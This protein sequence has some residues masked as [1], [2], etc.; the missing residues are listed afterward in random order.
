[1]SAPTT[2]DGR[3][4]DPATGETRPPSSSRRTIPN[5]QQEQHHPD[6]RLAPWPPLSKGPLPEIEP[7]LNIV[8]AL[9]E[10][11]AWAHA[12]EESV[13]DWKV[14][15]RRYAQAKRKY[16]LAAARARRRARQEPTERGRRT[17]GDI[18]GEVVERTHGEGE[19]YN[20]FLDAE[21]D[22]DIAKTAM[23]AARDQMDRLRTHISAAKI[24]DPRGP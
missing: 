22:L 21:A 23:F 12:H 5:R 8:T 20:E 6:A 9:D 7:D 3:P 11:D 13:A 17:S 16:E 4:I 19:S 18:D 1:M 14:A 15:K 2:R 24:L 10:L